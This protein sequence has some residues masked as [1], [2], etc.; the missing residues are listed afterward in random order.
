MR[1]YYETNGKHLWKTN[2]NYW[3]T[4]LPEEGNEKIN[5]NTH[6]QNISQEKLLIIKESGSYWLK[7]DRVFQG[8]TLKLNTPNNLRP[9]LDFPRLG[10]KNGEVI[11]LSTIS[12]W[13]HS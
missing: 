8:N 9:I 13:Q 3:K 2:K 6:I 5:S 10:E 4:I 12:G 11:Y 7:A 1:G